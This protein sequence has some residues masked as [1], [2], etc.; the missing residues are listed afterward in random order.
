MSETILFVVAIV[1][2]FF[3]YAIYYQ[4]IRPGSTYLCTRGCG[5]ASD[6][7][8]PPKRGLV[9]RQSR[10]CCRASH[11]HGE[12]HVLLLSDIGYM[13]AG[14]KRPAMPTTICRQRGPCSD[15]MHDEY[16]L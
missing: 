9:R 6:V 1:L 16:S 3:P 4:H 11:M 8:R 2:Y 14:R 13:V 10:R 7:P 15:Q 12:G 5:N